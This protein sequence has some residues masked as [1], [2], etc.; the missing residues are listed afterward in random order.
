MI[1]LAAAFLLAAGPWPELPADGFITGRAATS[2]DI[3]AGTAAF[4]QGGG[5]SPPMPLDIQI[6]QYACYTDDGGSRVRAV[7]IQAEKTP[8]GPVVGLRLSP[9]ETTLNLL[10][11]V[12]LLGPD[13]PDDKECR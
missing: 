2:D 6:P 12:T 10:S 4:A 7:L 3:K 9:D 5:D 8:M 1:S 13:R 11:E